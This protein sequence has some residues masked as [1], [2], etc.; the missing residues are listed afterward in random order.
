MLNSSKSNATGV[1]VFNFQNALQVRVIVLNGNPYFVAVDVANALGYC[2]P[3]DAV[4]AHC[5][6]A[7][8][9]RLSD[10]HGVP[11]IY[12][13][14]PESDVYRLIFR[15]NLPSAEKFQDW[16]YDE[17]LPTIRKTGYYGVQP[18]NTVS[19]QEYRHLEMMLG[20]ER[21]LRELCQEQRNYYMEA[22]LRRMDMMIQMLA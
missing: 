14:I 19:L 22:S 20:V 6:R 16:V 21:K 2:I 10:N 12:N 13:V 17:V 5:R 11:H 15:S 3:K 9:H 4:S 8:K 18:E 7:V 1:Q